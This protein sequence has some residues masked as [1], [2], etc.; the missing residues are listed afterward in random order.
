LQGEYDLP[1]GRIR[2]LPADET[3]VAAL[4]HDARACFIADS[5]DASDVLRGCRLDDAGGAAAIKVARF[6]Q[7]SVHF[8]PIRDEGGGSHDRRQAIAEIGRM[9]PSIL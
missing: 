4:R 3:G 8:R 1:A 5:K 2:R 9:R 7:V 6:G